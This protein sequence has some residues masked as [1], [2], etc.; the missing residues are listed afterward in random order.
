MTYGVESFVD[1]TR[2]K[3]ITQ[4]VEM[5]I[6]RSILGRTS[7]ARLPNQKILQKC[8]ITND[9]N[10]RKHGIVES[11]IKVESIFW[12]YMKEKLNYHDINIFIL[13]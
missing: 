1:T 11:D 10:I 7:M 6:L 9:M 13:S 8:S 3:Q 4:T 12:V 5:H 2:M